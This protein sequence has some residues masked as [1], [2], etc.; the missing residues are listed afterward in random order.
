MLGF[1]SDDPAMKEEAFRI[2]RA[3]E[4]FVNN[5]KNREEDGLNAAKSLKS[6]DY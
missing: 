5:A 6:E 1:T 3:Y 2:I 4:K